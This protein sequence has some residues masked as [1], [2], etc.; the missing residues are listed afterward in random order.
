MDL[1]YSVMEGGSL[2]N[3]AF[4]HL[5]STQSQRGCSCLPLPKGIT[6]SVKMIGLLTR[7]VE[8]TEEQ[9]WHEMLLGIGNIP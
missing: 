6:I 5:T 4:H 7:R 2:R 3:A 8:E 1:E 9:T